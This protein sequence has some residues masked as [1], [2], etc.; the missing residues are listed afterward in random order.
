MKK[1]ALI[2]L[3][4]IYT[5]A[6]IGFTIGQ[7]YCCGRLKSVSVTIT[8]NGQQKYNKENGNSGCCKTKYQFYKVGDNHF[9]AD[10]VANPGKYFTYLPSLMPSAEKFFSSAKETQTAYNNHAP[11]LHAGIPAYIFNCDFRI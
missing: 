5:A 6:T 3:I 8:E 11:P 2:L 4:C 1:I 10:I 9:A 7:F